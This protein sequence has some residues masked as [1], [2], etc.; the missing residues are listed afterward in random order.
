MAGLA[1]GG[2]LAALPERKEAAAPAPPPMVKPRALKPGDT[3]GLIAPSSYVFELWDL[4]AIAPRLAALELECKFGRNVRARRGYLA[5]TEDERL[6]D[7]HA[8]FADPRVAGVVCLGGGYGTER[9]LDRIDYGLIRRNPKI[10]IGYS[11][12]TGLHLAFGK[13]A[14]LV[15]FH[16]PVA[17]SA[18]P[19]WTLA[20]L[21]KALFSS[22]PIGAIDNPP[23]PDS[24]SP[25]FPRHTVSPGRAR[26]QTVGGNLT[27]ISTTMGTPYEIDAKGKILLLEDTGEAPYR[28]DRML[29]QLRLAGKFADAAGIVWGTCTDC[30][31]SR[32]SFEI[33]LSMSELLDDLLG[34]LG[35]PVLAG[36]VFGHTKE[37]AT[38]PLGVEAELDATAKTFRIVEAAALA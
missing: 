4:E 36:L 21:K 8:M 14:R 29:V 16:G 5:G 38:I 30:A 23:E 34:N 35:K 12:I 20:S 28:I 6:A 9:L 37:K 7:L 18:L 10:F 1:A 24:L 13:L 22:E 26:G 17:L 2:S 33:N 11:D 25:E 3:V 27:L 15:T 32:S 31:P 19:E